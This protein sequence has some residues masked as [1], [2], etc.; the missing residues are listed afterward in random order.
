MVYKTGWRSNGHEVDVV[1]LIQRKNLILHSVRA[2]PG[3]NGGS[4]VR[5]QTT[6]MLGFDQNRA[7]GF[8]ENPPLSV[9][10]VRLDLCAGCGLSGRGND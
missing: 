7:V 9:A 3:V 6:S 1:R 8:V 10:A 5:F 4:S 2:R